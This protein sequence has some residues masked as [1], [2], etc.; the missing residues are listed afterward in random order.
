MN[1]LMRQFGDFNIEPAND[2]NLSMYTP[3]AVSPETKIQIAGLAQQLPAMISNEAVSKMY[4][5]KFPEGINGM[6]TKLKRG[7]VSTMIKNPETQKFIASASL[8]EASQQAALL[9]TFTGLSVAT[10]QYFLAEIH[11]ELKII[12]Q[13]IDDI[14]KFLYG[15]KQAELLA[16][17]EF[18]RYAFQ[19]YESIMTHDEQRI[20]TLANLQTSKKV[21]LRDFIFYLDDLDST[22]VKKDIKANADK[23]ERLAR[24]ADMSVQ[25]FLVT[26]LL[27][28]YYAQNSD[29][30]YLNYMRNSI[31][32]IIEKADKRMLSSLTTFSTNVENHKKG[33]AQKAMDKNKMLPSIENRINE[34]KN[35]PAKEKFIDIRNVLD[36]YDASTEYIIDIDGNAYHKLAS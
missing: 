23:I 13:G 34:I 36:T 27:E 32:S 20:A 14:L 31:D 18:A 16:E 29:K 3:M 5:M 9:S 21:A 30:D 10:G 28:V 4:I 19:N 2:I 35:T 7:G 25:L 17:I 12:N 33:I 11:K 26:T 22:A 8:F 1:D 15:E 6:L 24:S